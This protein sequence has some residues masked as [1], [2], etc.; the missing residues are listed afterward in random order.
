MSYKRKV[1]RYRKKDGVDVEKD[2]SDHLPPIPNPENGVDKKLCNGDVGNVVNTRRKS[3]L[4]YN[5]AELERVKA[6]RD[7]MDKKKS[8]DRVQYTDE[9]GRVID[10]DE[11]KKLQEIVGEAYRKNIILT[12][13]QRAD[14]VSKLPKKLNKYEVQVGSKAV[15]P[16]VLDIQRK[17]VSNARVVQKMNRLKYIESDSSRGLKLSEDDAE[18]MFSRYNRQGDAK[19]DLVKCLLALSYNDFEICDYMDIKGHELSKLKKEIFYEEIVSSKSLTNEERFA[20]Y[21]MQQMEIVKDCDVLIERFKDTTQVS[22][23][24]SMLKTKAD[25]LDKIVQK[26]QEFGVIDKNPDKQQML[27]GT[28]DLTDA[29]IEQ[30]ESELLKTNANI[31]NVMKMTKEFD[32]NSIEDED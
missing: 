30:L 2:L 31:N 15:F 25:I 6:A 21:K 20:Q 28:I 17:R 12:D 18:E 19:K 5:K 8:K 29:T 7:N 22:A 14:L 16:A 23:L 4:I 32:L 3:E 10:Y 26:G 24:V 27:V 9:N 1:K 11:L 13:E